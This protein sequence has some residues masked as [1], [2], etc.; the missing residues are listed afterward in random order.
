MLVL[1]R[2]ADQE[3]LFPNLDIRIRVL[4][5]KGK[6]VKLGIDAPRGIPV[7]RPE[8][9]DESELAAFRENFDTGLNR[10]EMRNRLNAINL[11]A[12]LAQKQIEAD[13]P[14]AAE[15]TLK[16]LVED[17]RRLDAD[18][19]QARREIQHSA[20]PRSLRLLVVED[21]DNERELL[22]GLLRLHGF[23]VTTAVNG[24]DAVTRLQD[25]QLPDFVLLD[26]KMPELDGPQLIEHIR[27]TRRLGQL[28]VFAVSGTS[29]EDMGVREGYDVWFPKPL[30]PEQLIRVMMAQNPLTGTSA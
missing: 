27:S 15:T 13:M 1:S 18:V 25:E 6:I 23:D 17:L 21:D 29:P 2:R 20:G 3:L 14:A 22:A 4:Q 8:A 30:D 28:Q 26:M 11:G 12:R 5:V 19:G 7:L 24:A 16:R 9:C 10:H